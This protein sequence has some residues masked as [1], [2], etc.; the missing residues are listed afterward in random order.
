MLTSDTF[1]AME[2][3]IKLPG[4]SCGI[5]L[6]NGVP[7]I[8]RVEEYKEGVRNS[9]RMTRY[10]EVIWHT[11]PFTSKGY[12]SVEDIHMIVYEGSPI[13]VSLVFTTWGVWFI[14]NLFYGK[15]VPD[16]S[17]VYDYN[18]KVLEQLYYNTQRGREYEKKAVNKAIDRLNKNGI[19]NISFIPWNE[20][21]VP[22]RV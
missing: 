20:V 13:R 9:C 12:P 21:R 10:A 11:H 19:T 4:E 22:I 3:L 2:K 18:K 7:Y 16:P 15:P 8:E 6:E 17:H 1:L 14:Y 5:L